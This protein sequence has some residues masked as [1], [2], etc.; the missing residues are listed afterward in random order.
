MFSSNRYKIMFASAWHQEVNAS[1]RAVV[2]RAIEWRDC[3]CWMRTRGVVLLWTVGTATSELQGS[4]CL[5]ALSTHFVHFA[6]VHII[7]A[8]LCKSQEAVPDTDPVPNQTYVFIDVET[9]GVKIDRPRITEL[10]LIAVNRFGLQNVH[11]GP[12]S[13][14]NSK[15]L[16]L[17][18]RVLDKMTICIDPQK[19]VRDDAYRLT[20][21]SNER[22]AENRRKGFDQ[23]VID[24]ILA[25]LA[26]Q[27]TPVCLF[28]HN[29]FAF[30]YPMLK[31]EFFRLN[32]N[33]PPNIRCA[34]TL[35]AAR[36]IFRFDGNEP[37]RF[38]LV[39]LHQQL[40]QS[41]PNGAHNAEDDALTLLRVVQSNVVA[42]IDWADKHA[43]SFSDFDL[44]YAPSPSKRQ[45]RD[46]TT[47]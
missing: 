35:V 16:P 8:W 47:V 28:A 37:L 25:F 32:T 17:P 11:L 19:V 38:G 31:V 13:H 20:G 9:T 23:H 18:P 41:L 12:P 4:C 3:G 24:M 6:V 7:A 36:E 26:R 22:L 30:D 42:F 34:D 39:D 15:Q 40:F 45:R 1:S 27:P 43:L 29:G 2:T 44:L 10:C 46:Y 14:K 21:L 5:L 33:L